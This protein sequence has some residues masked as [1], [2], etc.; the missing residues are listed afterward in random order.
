MENTEAIWLQ[1]LAKR[2]EGIPWKDI[3]EAEGFKYSGTVYWPSQDRP[4]PGLDSPG[5]DLAP[6]ASG[7]TAGG[8]LLQGSLPHRRRPW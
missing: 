3:I 2:R 6:S 8:R 4:S 1:R 7:A 5:G